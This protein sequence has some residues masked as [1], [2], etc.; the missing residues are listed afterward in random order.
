MKSEQVRVKLQQSIEQ[1]SKKILEDGKIHE[2]EEEKLK[3]EVSDLQMR[4]VK[5][6][7]E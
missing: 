3:K 6:M 7:E 4:I 1:T 5:E 2:E